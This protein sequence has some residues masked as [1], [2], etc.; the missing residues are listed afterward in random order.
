MPQSLNR[1]SVGASADQLGGYSL[2]AWNYSLMVTTNTDQKFVDQ[3]SEGIGAISVS[4]YINGDMTYMQGWKDEDFGSSH[5]YVSNYNWFSM[6]EGPNQD[7]ETFLGL[8]LNNYNGGEN[9]GDPIDSDSGFYGYDDDHFSA[10]GPDGLYFDAVQQIEYTFDGRSLT[11]PTQELTDFQDSTLTIGGTL[12]Y[13]MID[14]PANIPTKIMG[15]DG[16]IS[17]DY[18]SWE[19]HIKEDGSWVEVFRFEEPQDQDGWTNVFV[20][21]TVAEWEMKDDQIVVTYK[22]DDFW[23]DAGGGPGIGQGT[24]IYQV[25]YTYE[26]INGNLKLLNEFNMCGDEFERFCLE[27]LE[28]EYQLDRG[29]LEEIKMVWE[30]E[31]TKTPN[32][33][34]MRLYSEP[35]RKALARHPLYKIQK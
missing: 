34:K 20:D 9:M 4:G 30:L 14:V 23:P 2:N 24:W 7:S 16:D 25:A 26:V 15:Y 33:R 13:S 28:T 12:S 35:M 29:S 8:N 1:V 27:M 6:F 32:L 31:F 19:I 10:Y 18:G 3:M 11:V 17:S 5:V 21:S 22:Y